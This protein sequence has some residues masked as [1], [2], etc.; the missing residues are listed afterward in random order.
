MPEVGAIL[1]K[2]EEFGTLEST[3]SVSPLISPVNGKVKAVNENLS[4]NPDLVNSDPYG[5]GWI[6]EIEMDASELGSM[7]DAAAYKKL[8]ESEGG[9]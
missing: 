9:H 8:L 3:K 1:T 2:G 6:M 5:E 4:D 7:L